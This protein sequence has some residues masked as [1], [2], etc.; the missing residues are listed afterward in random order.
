MPTALRLLSGLLLATAVAVAYCVLRDP[1]A[2]P[3]APSPVPA[4]TPPPGQDRRSELHGDAESGGRPAR[5]EAAPGAP[6]TATMPATPPP[7]DRLVGLVVYGRDGSPLAGAR[8]A[9]LRPL[10]GDGAVLDAELR[11]ATEQLDAT[12]TDAAGHFTFAVA[13]ARLHE[14]RVAHEDFA[15]REVTHA[16]GGSTTRIELWPG[17]TLRGVVTV[18]DRPVA[19]AQVI[20]FAKPQGRLFTVRTDHRG[21]YE[22]RNVPPGQAV[23][24][25]LANN[26]AAPSIESVVFVHGEELV[27][28]VDLDPGRETSGRVTDAATGAPLSGAELG[29]EPA[30]GRT[31]RTGADGRYRFQGFPAPGERTLYA[32][33]PGYAEQARSVRSVAPDADGHLVIDFALQRGAV[34]TGRFLDAN[35]QPVPGARVAAVGRHPPEPSL[36]VTHSV[37]TRSDADGHFRLDALAAGGAYELAVRKAGHGH[38]AL[39]SPRL[40]PADGPLDL[41]TIVLPRA[42]RVSGRVLDEHG[43]PLPDVDVSL[44]G[45]MPGRSADTGV[46]LVG[47]PFLNTRRTRS[48]AEGRFHF[49]DVPGGRWLVTVRHG[50]GGGATR[51]LELA[52]GEEI[53]DADVEVFVGMPIGGRVL[54]AAGEPLGVATVTAH[55]LTDEAGRR[56]ARPSSRPGRAG[57]PR[58]VPDPRLAVG[59][60]PDANPTTARRRQSSGSPRAHTRDSQHRHVPRTTAQHN[61]IAKARA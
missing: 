57:P 15:P 32:R 44:S 20:V 51:T 28:H 30:L 4:D 53:L 45:S 41:G 50:F 52:N 2:A 8:V 34:A 19:D 29:V 40:A 21:Y 13:P 36:R 26:V 58:G 31:V 5:R 42:G 11:D 7:D 6:A 59:S 24:G 18:E 35:D 60:L 16:Y 56:L 33:A 43:T 23:I 38:Y 47:A 37:F 3:A 46:G 10:A 49:A 39:P 1:G 9:L 54:S 25:V 14:L 55:P 22:H 17:A 61:P 48:T 27:H 12:R